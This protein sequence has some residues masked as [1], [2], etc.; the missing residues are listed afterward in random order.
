MSYP[1]NPETIILKNKFYPKGLRERDA[2][3]YYQRVKGFLLNQ[4][5][6]RELMFAIM[7]DINKPI[8]RRK[9]SGKFLYLTPSNYN[10]LITGRT[11]TIYSTMKFYETLAIVDIDTDSFDKSKEP[12]INVYNVL[13]E[14][15]FIRNL[16][17]RYTGKTSF[18]IICELSRKM[19]IDN[20]RL[21]LERYLISKKEITNKYTINP[22]RTRGVPN[23][24]LWAS[25]K[26]RGAFISLGSLSLLGLKCME[27]NPA[28]LN[29]FKQELARI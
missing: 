5:Q 15:D 24:D 6:G 11:I 10:E 3:G 25:N 26:I 14:A 19:K 16:S 28:Q 1:G 18:H 12:T 20:A 7:T 22:S 29:S 2:Y 8:I 27:I 9:I 21:L 17:I 23:I 13:K 4:V